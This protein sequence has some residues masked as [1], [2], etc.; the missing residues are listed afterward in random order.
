MTK[1][2]RILILCA[3]PDDEVIGVGGTILNYAK[4]G[5]DSYVVIFSGGEKSNA[6][7][8]EKKLVSIREKE[9]QKAGEILNAKKIINLKLSDMKLYKEAHEKE[10]KDKIR[11]II[12]KYKPEK[13]FTHAI[14]D[15]LFPDHRAV[16]DCV[17]EIVKEF[18]KKEKKYPVYTFNI[19]TLNVRKRN[20]PK[21]IVD[22]TNEFPEKVKALK[23]FKSQSLALLQLTPGIYLKALL[24][25]WKN[26]TKYAEEFYKI[27]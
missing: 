23:C 13:I 14:D 7:Y 26:G 15:M 11:D 6:L 22:I 17:L 12:K 21:L 4:K 18:N 27:E 1:K 5:I 20:T 8:K 25:G 3:H 9:S 19:W 10:T 16:H 2:R 24:A